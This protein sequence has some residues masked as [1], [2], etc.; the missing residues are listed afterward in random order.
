M[1]PYQS[2]YQ[3]QTAKPDPKQAKRAALLMHLKKG[4]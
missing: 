3:P 2:P 1:T 4:C